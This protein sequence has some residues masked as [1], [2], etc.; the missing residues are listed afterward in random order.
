MINKII[1]SFLEWSLTVFYLLWMSCM[2]LIPI[3]FIVLIIYAFKN[4]IFGG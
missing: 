4:F 3:V 2:V 1:D